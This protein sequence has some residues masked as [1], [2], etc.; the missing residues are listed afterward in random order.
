MSSGKLYDTSHFILCLESLCVYFCNTVHC[1]YCLLY[2]LAMVFRRRQIEE[3]NYIKS[4]G[5]HP[6]CVSY[7][8]AW[9]EGGHI[10]IQIELCERGTYVMRERERR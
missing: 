1:T 10:H 9:E 3:A 5:R 4:L 6:H 8:G 7:Y 2:V